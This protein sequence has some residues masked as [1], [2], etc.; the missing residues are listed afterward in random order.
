LKQLASTIKHTITL[1]I[2]LL[3]APLAALEAV[4]KPLSTW[5]HLVRTEK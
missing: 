1:L 4:P 2:A 3:L 5:Q